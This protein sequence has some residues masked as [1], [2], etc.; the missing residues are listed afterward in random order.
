ML[1]FLEGLLLNPDPTASRFQTTSWTL[2]SRAC[3]SAQDLEQLLEMYWSPVYA[4]LRRQGHG[5]HDAADLTQGFLTEIVLERNF[6]ERADPDRGRFRA[7]LLSALRKFV[8]DEYRRVRGREGKRARMLIPDNPAVLAQVEPNITEDPVRV[9]DRQWAATVLGIALQRLEDACQ[10]EGLRSHW[11][12]FEARVKFPALYG[13]EPATID[14]LLRSVDA[15]GPE[16]ISSML[17][18]VKR[19]FRG[20]L[21]D[22]VAETLDDPNDIESELANLNRFLTV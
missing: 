1:N 13:S 16:E 7:F 9:F 19:K 15:R 8:V 12:V 21:R 20:V 10:R 17:Y 18:T 2:I 22:V 14:S 6:I 4:F 3:G 11:V 5:P